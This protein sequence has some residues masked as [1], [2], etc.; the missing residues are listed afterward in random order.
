[1]RSLMDLNS[2]CS[3]ASD[4]LCLCVGRECCGFCGNVQGARHSVFKGAEQPALLSPRAVIPAIHPVTLHLVPSS[5]TTHSH[6]MGT[7]R[8]PAAS[9]HL[10]NPAA[11]QLRPC[12]QP[13]RIHSAGWK[14]TLPRTKLATQV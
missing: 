4:R 5:T 1:M 6:L 13:A 9:I 3:S 12:S 2:R 8:P 10:T 7:A 11:I 14:G